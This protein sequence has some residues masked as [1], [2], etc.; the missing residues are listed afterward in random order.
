MPVSHGTLPQLSVSYLLAS[1]P[2][3]LRSK[4][5]RSPKQSKNVDLPCVVPLYTALAYYAVAFF[6]LLSQATDNARFSSLEMMSSSL[7]LSTTFS[8]ACQR[9]LPEQHRPILDRHSVK[10]TPELCDLEIEGA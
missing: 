9:D 3:L 7:P 6:Q 4:A 8:S 2:V 5:N 1:L 10:S